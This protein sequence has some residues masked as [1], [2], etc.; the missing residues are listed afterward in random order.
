MDA[1]LYTGTGATATITNTAG[2]K[3]DLIWN[4]SRSNAADNC[5]TDSVRGTNSQLISD[6]TS[7]Q[8]SNTNQITA[9]NSNGFSLGADNLGYT[10]YNAFTYVGWQWQAGQGSSSSN[11]N[12]SITSTVSVNASA[13][14]SVVTYTGTGSAATVGHGLGVAPSMII[15][16]KRSS[17]SDWG[18]YHISTGNTNYLLLDSTAASASSSTYWNNTSP[19]SSVFS[20]GT[21][22]P[23]NIST[24][25]YVAY[26]WAQI[27][28]FSKFGSY[29][30]NG[31]ADNTFVYTGFRPKYLLIK[32]TTAPTGYESWF[33]FDSVRNTYNSANLYLNPNTSGAEGA[34]TAGTDYLDILSNGFKL[35][36]T[37]APG[38][39]G[40][41]G[42]TYIYAAFAENPFKNALAR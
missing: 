19:T 1:T 6:N 21:A 30:A 7:A 41:S 37:G 26:C 11:T 31:S 22:D 34:G 12:G 33:V 27:A 38:V 25:T 28:G 39:N 5:L 8:L 15:T 18:V 23:V 29:V 3:P 9:F 2:F 40:N 17:T 10:N 20:I 16:K 35:R 13:G 42:A 4:K 24:A 36:G 14:F 32:C